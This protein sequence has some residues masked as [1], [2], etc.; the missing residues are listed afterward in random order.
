ME[1]QVAKYGHINITG[2][3]VF[4]MISLR[5]TDPSF[6]FEWRA[7]ENVWNVIEKNNVEYIVER[8]EIRR[9]V[10]CRRVGRASSAKL[11]Y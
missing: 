7:M 4:I 9:W 3:C 5:F 6:Y 2:N 8:E 10:L 11:K 1:Q